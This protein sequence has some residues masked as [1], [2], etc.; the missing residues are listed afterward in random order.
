MARVSAASVQWWSVARVVCA[1][2]GAVELDAGG[3]GMA[4][5]AASAD[6]RMTGM[7]HQRHSDRTPCLWGACDEQPP[8]LQFMLRGG[9][10]QIVGRAESPQ[11]ER[12]TLE[13]CRRLQHPHL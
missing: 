4:V 3:G 7:A 12:A 11:R 5:A 8:R 1:G 13:R 10:H 9:V 6:R 2:R